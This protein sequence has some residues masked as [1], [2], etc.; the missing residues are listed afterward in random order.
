MQSNQGQEQNPEDER[1]PEDATVRVFIRWGAFSGCYT[2]SDQGG[3]DILRSSCIARGT[4]S[5][6]IASS[7]QGACCR[8]RLPRLLIADFCRC[9]QESSHELQFSSSMTFSSLLTFF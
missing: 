4:S 6:S 7:H 5:T 2:L 1:L 8:L 9:T 3:I